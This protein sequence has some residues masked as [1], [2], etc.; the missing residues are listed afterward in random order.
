MVVKRKTKKK[1]GGG[2]G[3]PKMTPGF[4][5]GEKVKV[6]K[7]GKIPGGDGTVVGGCYRDDYVNVSVKRSDG[8]SR[9][10]CMPIKNVTK[11]GGAKKTKKKRGRG[12]SLGGVVENPWLKKGGH[13][14]VAK[15]VWPKK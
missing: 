5:K 14:K 13:K 6:R 2:R 15:K 9:L 1:K 10:G 8:K 7:H 4:I 12:S 11:V 3:K